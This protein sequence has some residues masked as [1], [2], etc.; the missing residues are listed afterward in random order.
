MRTNHKEM[1]QVDAILC[2]DIHLRDTIPECRTDDFL[3]AQKEKLQFLCELQKKY[4]CPIL[5]G[6]DLFHHWK[7]SPWLLS[8]ALNNLPDNTIVI[9]GQ[10]DLPAHNIDN[11]NK[12]G[13]YVL[14]SAG[15][16]ELLLDDVVTCHAKSY[17]EGFPYGAELQGAE[18]KGSSNIALIHHLVY[19]SE[20]PFPGADHKGGTAK[21]IMRKMPNFK[22]IVSGDNHVSFTEEHNG[23]LLV[24]PGS[25]MRT[26]AAQVN[27][28]PRVYLWNA[29]S[30]TVIPAYFPIEKGVVSRD[31]LISIEEREE[32]ISSFVSR[33]RDDIE[34]GLSFEDNMKRYIASNK[35]SKAV[36]KEIWQC[37]SK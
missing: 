31:H 1:K 12:S 35:V 19:K 8:F 21:S 36:Q 16:I 25:M 13:I 26:T 10:H 6:G 14:A 23:R 18:N 2:S 5:H 20:L 7:P 9:P 29:E 17:V 4:E 22:L 15:K 3:S 24:N 27:H 28:K 33:L 32:R 34:I 37:I 11:I 30:N